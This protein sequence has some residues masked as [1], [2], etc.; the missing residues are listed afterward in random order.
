[1]ATYAQAQA[2]SPLLEPF[3][4]RALQWGVSISEADCGQLTHAVWVSHTE[5]T[6]CIRYYPSAGLESADATAPRHK[7]AVLF[8]HGDHLAG[9]TPLG[10]YGKITPQR[11]LDTVL[12]N[13]QQYKVPYILVAR[14]GVYGSSGD[15]TQRRR[16]KEFHSM[17]AAVD[18]IKAR[19]AL[20]QVVLAGQSGGSTAAA[21]I[22]TLGRQ[23]VKCVAAGSGGYAVKELAVIK[24]QKLG[25][26]PRRGCDGTGYCDPYD[27]IEHV[28]GIAPDP[29]RHIYV[30][31]DPQD[32]NTVFPLQQAFFDKVHAA[33]HQVTLME[34]QGRG[35]DRHSMSY[36]TFRVAGAC[37]RGLPV[38]AIAGKPVSTDDAPAPRTSTGSAPE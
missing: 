4:E 1:M 16:A 7:L 17:N 25:V 22:L 38:T 12:R 24:W 35:P 28:D 29:G 6:E 19:Y 10:D 8:F 30:I 34:A 23:D 33:G 36:V 18:A 13:E 2:P 11:L 15:H 9:K 27:V 21:A 3:S 26:S 37:A 20:D 5:G 31:G 14:P 32:Q